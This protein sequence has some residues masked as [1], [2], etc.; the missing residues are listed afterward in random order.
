MTEKCFNKDYK[1][2][3]L[4]KVVRS[5]YKT[6]SNTQSAKAGQFTALLPPSKYLHTPVLRIFRRPTTCI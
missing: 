5:G 1:F 4:M 3:L 6:S 2:L